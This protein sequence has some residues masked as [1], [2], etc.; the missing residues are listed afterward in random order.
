L[1]KGLQRILKN[2]NSAVIYG[3]NA[4]ITIVIYDRGKAGSGIIPHDKTASAALELDAGAPDSI[5]LAASSE[6]AAEALTRPSEGREQNFPEQIPE[7]DSE[8][9][10]PEIG[11]PPEETGS[12]T[13]EV[14]SGTAQESPEP[15]EPPAVPDTETATGEGQ[16]EIGQHQ[17]PQP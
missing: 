7:P 11:L 9:S 16:P 8:G 14:G 17:D 15:A 4:E 2:L 13:D 3:S 6:P 10:K 1:D 5:Q 12:S